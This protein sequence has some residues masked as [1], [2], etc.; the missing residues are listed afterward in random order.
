MFVEISLYVKVEFLAY[1]H[2]RFNVKG[3]GHHILEL[4]VM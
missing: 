1:Y 4:L 3:E 2:K